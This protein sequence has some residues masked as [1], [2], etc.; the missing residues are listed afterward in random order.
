M[1]NRIFSVLH[2][3]FPRDSVVNQNLMWTKVP[4]QLTTSQFKDIIERWFPACAGRQIGFYKLNQRK[5]MV[6]IT[7]STTPRD[8][9]GCCQKRVVVLQIEDV[10]REAT[11]HGGNDNEDDGAP[12]NFV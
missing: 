8:L 11:I 6:R 4:L 7:P 1:I 2:L 9:L 10:R 3:G 5:K 12:L